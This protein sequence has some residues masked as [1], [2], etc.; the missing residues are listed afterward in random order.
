MVTTRNLPIHHAIVLLIVMFH[1]AEKLPAQESDISFGTAKSDTRQSKDKSPSVPQW[2]EDGLGSD[3]GVMRGKTLHRLTNEE[4]IDFLPAL[5]ESLLGLLSDGTK[6]NGTQTSISSAVSAVNSNQQS[7]F[8]NGKLAKQL[9]VKIGAP[10]INAIQNELKQS[11]SQPDLNHIHQTLA[12]I[13]APQSYAIML[14]ALRNTEDYPLQLAAAD[15]FGRLKDPNAI[16]TLIMRFKNA[17]PEVQLGIITA[18]GDI[19]SSKATPFLVDLLDESDDNLLRTQAAQ[20]LEKIKDPLATDAL[21]RANQD[22]LN[23]QDDAGEGATKLAKKALS[24]DAQQESD[25][26]LV[27]G[28]SDSN[29]ETRKATVIA[30]SNLGDPNRTTSP[31]INTLY[32]DLSSEVRYEVIWALSKT[33]TP[34]IRDAFIKTLQSDTYH[35]VR[36]IAVKELR[37][38]HDRL[39]HDAIVQAVGLDPHPD[40]RKAAIKTLQDMEDFDGQGLEAIKQAFQ[41]DNSPK[42]KKY[43]KDVYN[44]ISRR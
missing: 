29:D 22:S 32:N 34:Q 8:T 4:K 42:V 20:S 12:E 25:T 16:P 26:K 2:V 7:Q 41:N 39:S 21:L 5:T 11:H 17:R 37:H 27:R 38:Y 33:K 6:V 36:K 19:G 9:L 14:K 1:I 15:Y 43:A 35:H 30:L 40:V 24:D 10:A 31:L 18:L 13:A 23:Q 3:D 28:L 44:D